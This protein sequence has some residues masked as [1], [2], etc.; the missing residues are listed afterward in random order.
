MVCFITTLKGKNSI[1]SGDGVSCQG[2]GPR[3]LPIGVSR[4]KPSVFRWGHHRLPSPQVSACQ[5]LGFF[6]FQKEGQ[7]HLLK[8]PSNKKALDI[9]FSMLHLFSFF[10][11]ISFTVG[12]SLKRKE[13][14]TI[15]IV[16]RWSHQ[17]GSFPGGRLCVC[18]LSQTSLI[19]CDAVD[20][21]PPGSS[22][23][24]IL[25]ARI[26]EWVVVPSPRVSS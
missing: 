12:K 7:N 26:L 24:G 5:H 22:V 15:K 8:Y 16:W 4:P 18:V 25:Q 20:C 6:G 10:N 3:L 2:T 1:A 21:S 19:L 9:S 23:R 14:R 11:F 13:M 17:R